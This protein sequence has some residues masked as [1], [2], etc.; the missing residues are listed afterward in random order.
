MNTFTDLQLIRAFKA[1]SKL[2]SLDIM[3]GEKEYRELES[4]MESRKLFKHD[5]KNW[6]LFLIA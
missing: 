3:V 2:F 5:F 4:Y 6:I 1:F